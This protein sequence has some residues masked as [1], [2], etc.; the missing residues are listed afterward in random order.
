MQKF[1]QEDCNVISVDWRKGAGKFNYIKSVQNTRV[2]GAELGRW[3]I[4][5]FI[6]T[7]KVKKNF[8]R[9]VNHMVEKLRMNP[10]NF[11][12]IGHSLGAHIVSYVSHHFEGKIGRMTGKFWSWYFFYRNV[13]IY[14]KKVWTPQTLALRLKNWA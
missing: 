4:R 11:H 14:K 7:I 3:K 2:V 9:L 1:A 5:I 10:K 8:F 6:L 13:I 12:L